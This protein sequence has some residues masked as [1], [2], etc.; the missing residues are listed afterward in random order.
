MLAGLERLLDVF[1]SLDEVGKRRRMLHQCL[2]RVVVRQ[3]SL[4]V[5]V[6][7]DPVILPPDD[8]SDRDDELL[9]ISPK[10]PGKVHFIVLR[11]PS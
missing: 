5:H 8:S 4:E 7:A 11:R 3:E 6:R 2:S 1:E 10:I 9:N